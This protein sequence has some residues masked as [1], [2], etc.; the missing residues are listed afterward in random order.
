[1]NTFTIY[2]SLFGKKLKYRCDADNAKEA[3]SKACAFI[4]SKI[5]ID[6]IVK[7]DDA[8]DYLK[9]IFGIK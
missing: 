1:M 2:F 6:S 9:S 8:L 3:E 7:E 4:L 5:E